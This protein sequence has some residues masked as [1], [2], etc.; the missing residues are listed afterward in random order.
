MCSK[1]CVLGLQTEPETNQTMKT[2]NSHA[3]K[4]KDAGAPDAWR[5]AIYNARRETIAYAS[6][7]DKDAAETNAALLVKALTAFKP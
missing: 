2:T 5:V 4:V 1:A 3:F 6:G 7:G